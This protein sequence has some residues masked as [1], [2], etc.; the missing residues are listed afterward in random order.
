VSF[1]EEATILN[2]LQHDNIVTCFGVAVMP[3]ALCLVTEFC[4]Y[5]SLYDFLHSLEY[6]VRYS[7][8]ST[9][10]HYRSH[11]VPQPQS[12]SDGKIIGQELT[13]TKARSPL[14]IDNSI[15][16]KENSEDRLS[17]LEEGRH[18]TASKL[19]NV[20]G[21][22]VTNILQSSSIDIDE[23]HIDDR[24]S[25]TR[26]RSSVLSTSTLEKLGFS[27]HLSNDTDVSDAD[28]SPGK[29]F[30][31]RIENMLHSSNLGRDNTSFTVGSIMKSAVSV[32]RS[33]DMGFGLGPSTAGVSGRYR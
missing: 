19:A 7:R 16:K 18:S 29:F 28:P 31:D 26:S 14:T 25:N 24:N 10:G 33:Q 6:Q 20:M 15:L 12:K 1:C 23:I 27:L 5:G 4:L 2:S 3:P 8:S 9:D 11:V 22:S 17:R 32:L 13:A 21:E 30:A